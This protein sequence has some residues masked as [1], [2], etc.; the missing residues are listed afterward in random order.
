MMEYIDIEFANQ[1]V[2]NP[3]YLDVP[4]EEDTISG[5]INTNDIVREQRVAKLFDGCLIPLSSDRDKYDSPSIT[6]PLK[7]IIDENKSSIVYIQDNKF[8]HFFFCLDQNYI[9]IEW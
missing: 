9:A 4:P 5:L 1:P 2:M 3:L 7:R 6:T 8:G